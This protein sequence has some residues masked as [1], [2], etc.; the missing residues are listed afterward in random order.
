MKLGIAIL[1][2]LL[3]TPLMSQSENDKVI[4]IQ[5]SMLQQ[6]DQE[7]KQ[8]TKSISDLE[9][10]QGVQD[11]D[12]TRIKGDVSQLK[13]DVIRLDRKVPITPTSS[14][15][16]KHIKID[17]TMLSNSGFLGSASNKI[18]RKSMGRHAFCALTFV[19]VP[20]GGAYCNVFPDRNRPDNWILES[21]YGATCIA[22]C[23]W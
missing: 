8:N 20:S 6:L 13:D 21:G 17:S 14:I 3:A 11:Q 5:Q 22:R 4:A 18:E 23:L 9:S 7:T 1:T 16:K 12:L 10:S 2:T 15:E 19:K